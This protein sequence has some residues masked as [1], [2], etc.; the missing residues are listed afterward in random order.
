MNAHEEEWEQVYINV[1]DYCA[2]ND[3]IGFLELHPAAVNN[4]KSTSGWTLLHQAMFWG[5]DKGIVERLRNLGADPNLRDKGDNKDNKDGKLAIERCEPHKRAVQQAIWDEVFG[6]DD[7]ASRTALLA[8]AKE[9]NFVSV[10]QQLKQRPYLVNTQSHRGWSV[11]H[12]AAFH[13]VPQGLLVVLLDLKASPHLRTDEGKTPLDILQETDPG[14]T[15][16]FPGAVAT[17]FKPGDQV[18]VH[19]AERSAS[20]VVDTIAN[21]EAAVTLSDGQHVTVSPFRLSLVVEVPDEGRALEYKCSMCQTLVCPSWKLSDECSGEPHPMCGDCMANSL[22]AQYTT[23]RIPFKCDQ[24]RAPVDLDKFRKRIPGRL[25]QTTWPPGRS[26]GRPLTLL[27]FDN[28]IQNVEER[29]KHDGSAD[30]EGFKLAQ[31]AECKFTDQPIAY[32]GVSDCP[33]IRA[34]PECGV[35]IEYESECKHMDCAVCKHR[36]CFLCLKT[37]REHNADIESPFDWSPGVACPV[38]P[39]QTALP[40]PEGAASGL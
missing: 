37:Q 35:L 25:F 38:A 39:R 17:G 7:H 28:F 34:C 21:K 16:R 26:D 6:T 2:F 18:V 32:C 40:R 1:K 29:L 5:V 36:F 8:A 14:S 11:L 20:G 9:G 23:F 3:A 22:W 10:L 30:D 19:Q 13:V 27:E 12:Q 24:C 33:K 31:L 15:L 4:K